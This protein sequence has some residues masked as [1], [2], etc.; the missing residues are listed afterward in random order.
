MNK[1]RLIAINLNEYNLDFLKIGAK[2][3]NCQ[4]IKKFLNLKDIKTFSVDK[5]QDKNLD[6]WVQNISINSGQRS[7]KHKTFNLGEKIPDN[8]NQI[9]DDLSKKITNVLF[10]V[11]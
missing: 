2:K 1:K 7:S 4:N 8:I 3:Y 10:G 5:I 6:P 11:Q 9:W